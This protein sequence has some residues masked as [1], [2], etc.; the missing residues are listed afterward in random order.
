MRFFSQGRVASTSPSHGHTSA[1][2]GWWLLPVHSL[3]AG[4][5]VAYVFLCVQGKQYAISNHDKQ[6]QPSKLSQSDVVALLSA[7]LTLLRAMAGACITLLGWR[8]LFFTLQQ[9]GASLNEVNRMLA[10]RM[11]PFLLG[12]TQLILWALFLLSIPPQ[13]ASPILQ[14]AVSWIPDTHY[15][16]VGLKN[17]TTPGPGGPWDWINLWSQDR[18]FGVMRAVGATAKA[19]IDNFNYTTV[20]GSPSIP[21]RRLVDSLVGEKI[22]G[23]VANV[24][25]PFFQV[26]S[27]DWPSSLDDIGDDLDFLDGIVTHADEPLLVYSN[28]LPSSPFYAGTIATRIMLAKKEI[29]EPGPNTTVNG[30]TTFDWPSPHVRHMKQW[31]V[32][33]VVTDTLDGVNC[34]GNSSVFGSLGNVYRRDRSVIDGNGGCFLYGRLDYSAGVLHCHDCALVSDGVVE[35]AA[36]YTADANATLRPDPLV[37][38]AFAMIPEVLFYMAY[39]NTSQAPTWD[40]VNGWALGMIATS[41]QASWNA[42]AN[43]LTQTTFTDSSDLSDPVAVLRAEITSWRVWLWLGLNACL[44]VSC[45]ALAILQRRFRTGVIGDPALTALMLDATAVVKSSSDHFQDVRTLNKDELSTRVRL[46]MSPHNS[47]AYSQSVRLVLDSSA[48]SQH[49]L[50][51]TA[52]E[53]ARSP[54]QG[55]DGAFKSV[56]TIEY[57]ILR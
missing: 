35:A 37:D 14:G 27:L 1:I 30:T 32:L 11:P 6:N 51:Y 33:A 16:P 18:L 9:H 25:L 17:I 24:T 44:T 2:L 19:S 54:G 36:N 40:N 13:F 45:A 46:K 5:F 57:S 3:V 20:A 41:Y 49:P 47:D 21:T 50:S 55:D 12:R 42:L 52:V 48:T 39:T 56:S 31:I 29:W 8:M 15:S 53:Q 34:M 7:V 10:W 22:G 28:W 26:H 43:Q 23:K 38:T 4:I